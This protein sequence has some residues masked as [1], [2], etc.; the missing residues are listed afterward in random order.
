MMGLNMQISGVRY[1]LALFDEL[2]FCAAARRCNI[3]QPSLTSAIKRLEREVE[4]ELF[5]RRPVVTAT[6]LALA[7]RPHFEAI[8]SATESVHAEARRQRETCRASA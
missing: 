6:P 5:Y 1:F 2:N 8:I 4:G 7:L 3:S